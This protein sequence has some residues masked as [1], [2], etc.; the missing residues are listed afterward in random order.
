MFPCKKVG[1]SDRQ[2]KLGKT[3][4]SWK[5]SILKYLIINPTI[6]NFCFFI[7][8]CFLMPD[9]TYVEVILFLIGLQQQTQCFGSPEHVWTTDFYIFKL[10][11]QRMRG[12]IKKIFT[13]TLI[14]S[15]KLNLGLLSADHY[16]KY[17]D[18][19]SWYSIKPNL[20][21]C[22]TTAPSILMICV[23]SSLITETDPI[24]STP[25]IE[26]GIKIHFPHQHLLFHIKIPLPRGYDYLKVSVQR[27][28]SAKIYQ[29]ISNSMVSKAQLFK[30]FPG[31]LERSSWAF[32]DLNR[33]PLIP[34]WCTL[35]LCDYLVTYL[36]KRGFLRLIPKHTGAKPKKSNALAGKPAEWEGKIQSSETPQDLFSCLSY[37][38]SL[39][40]LTSS[41]INFQLN[42]GL[43][44]LQQW[45]NFDRKDKLKKA[46][47]HVLD[48]QEPLPSSKFN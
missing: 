30:Q 19:T 47:L 28:H 4:Q 45:T 36:I 6:S 13:I 43:N 39:N 37:K 1:I 32:P 27:M 8:N 38:L 7:K 11:W 34:K 2:G 5:V 20:L 48:V 21:P 46:P 42:A 24:N 23:S 12:K 10:K 26:A 33:N 22:T 17:K 9:E 35:E 3:L 16:T 41:T 44:F 18:N 14:T 25:T 31:N 29:P 40:P 15:E